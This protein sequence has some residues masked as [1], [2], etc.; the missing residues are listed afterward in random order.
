MRDYLKNKLGVPE[1]WDKYD[2]Q[3]QRYSFEDIEEIFQT[4]KKEQ[5]RIGGVSG[6]FTEQDIEQAWNDGVNS[7]RNR[8]GEFDI[9]NYR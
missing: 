5:L 1:N 6:S 8:S 7:E 2:Y 4:Y 9:D 3:T